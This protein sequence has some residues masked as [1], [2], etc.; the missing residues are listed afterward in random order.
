[1]KR[2]MRATAALGVVV[3][4]L[5]LSASAEAERDRRRRRAGNEVVAWAAD[6]SVVVFAEPRAGSRRLVDLV[7]RRVPSG[8]EIAR[9][10]VHPGPC[11]GVIDGQV[12][13]SHAC[14]L[15]RLRPELPRSLR[16]T[17][18][19]VAA[20]ERNRIQRL[21]LRADGS[22]VERE[23]PGLGVV[24]RGRTEQGRGEV[25][26][27]VLEVARV[28]RED[29]RELDRRAVRP[30]SRRHW[31]LL[32]AGEDS[33][34]VVGNGLLERVGTRPRGARPARSPARGSSRTAGP[35]GPDRG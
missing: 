28:G 13:V 11:A 25:R 31:I 33:F 24:L 26:E 32:Q 20:N 5:A 2:T 3:A 14:A 10:Q 19:H 9:R 29:V 15:T 12:A 16:S 21:S 27:A 30:R 17:R 34:I 8:E 18:F 35:A 7:A 23:L 22:T 1:M 4:M 6:G